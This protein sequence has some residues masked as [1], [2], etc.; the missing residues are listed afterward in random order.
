MDRSVLT[1]PAACTGSISTPTESFMEKSLAQ[2]SK[3]SLYSHFNTC[4]ENPQLSHLPA[5]Q[6]KLSACGRRPLTPLR[7]KSHVTRLSLPILS[8]STIS[9]D[10]DSVTLFFD[11][12]GSSR[13]AED[14]QAGGLTVA[15]THLPLG[16]S[17]SNDT[18]QCQAVNQLSPD[19]P[20]S[21]LKRP[22]SMEFLDR[23]HQT[24]RESPLKTRDSSTVVREPVHSR[25]DTEPSV[26]ARNGFGIATPSRVVRRQKRE[27]AANADEKKNRRRSLPQ[28]FALKRNSLPGLNL[29]KYVFSQTRSNSREKNVEN[30]FGHYQGAGRRR[31][32]PEEKVADSSRSGAVNHPH[33]SRKMSSASTSSTSSSSSGTRWVLNDSREAKEGKTR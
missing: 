13:N 28:M 21:S 20:T 10:R 26:S 16:R 30:D 8:N 15:K 27:V 6:R 12:T 18:G 19:P 4:Y 14:N 33:N 24:A 17:I 7:V 1:R 31:S 5:T 32:L 23:G 9:A 25:S 29:F 2:Q 3:L 22:C 11:G